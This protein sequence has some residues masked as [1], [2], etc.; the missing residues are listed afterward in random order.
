[1]NKFYSVLVGG[2]LSALGLGTLPAVGQ[3][4]PTPIR[5]CSTEEINAQIQA[6]LKRTIPGYDPTRQTAPNKKLAAAR[7]GAVTYTLPVIV[8]VIHNGEAVGTGSN[9]SQAQVQSQLDVLNEDYRNLNVDGAQVPSVYQ[10]RRGDMQVQFVNA[11]RDPNG[12]TLAEPGIDRINRN[13][14]GWTAPPYASTNY[15]NGTIKPNSYWDPSRYINIWVLNLGGGLLGYAQ[16][17]DNTAGLGGLS[18]LGGSA[19]TDGVVVLYTSYGSRVKVPNG[20]FGGANNVYDR[21]RTLTHELGHWFGFRH[22]WGDDDCGSDYCPDTPVQFE[23]NYGCVTFPHVTCSNVTGDMSMNYMDYTDD[24]CMY[25]FT[26]GQKDR[27]QAVMQNTPRRAELANSTV[28]CTSVA[29]ATA[30]NS[31]PACVGGSITL[32]ATG[33]AGATYTWDGP[34]GF[35]STAQNP[36]IS[37]VT[38]LA[39]GLY[40][41]SVANGGC[42]GVASTTVVVNNIPAVPVLTPVTACPQTAITLTPT[43]LTPTTSTLPNENFNGTATGWTIANTG[44]AVTTWQYSSGY[45]YANFGVSNF[46]LNGSRFAIANSDAGGSGS[47]TNT[48]LTSPVFSTV[49]YSALQLSFQQIYY[50]YEGVATVEATTDGGTTW[51]AVATYRGQQGALGTASLGA[52]ITSTVNLSYVL[53]KPSVQLRWHYVDAYGALWAIDNVQFTATVPTLTYNWT[54]VSGD[55]L[56]TTTNAASLTATPTQSSVYR[57][58]VGFAGSSCTSSST[59]SVNVYPTPVL[60]SSASVACTGSPA[61]LSATNLAGFSPTYAWTLVS[62][63]GLPAATNAAT[64]AVTPTQNSVYRLTVTYPGNC[65]L[66]STVSV[67]VVPTPTLVASASAICSGSTS[68]LS[69]TNVPATGYTYKWE[70]VS[71]NGLSATATTP[72]ITVNPTQ[73]SLYRLT[74]T[75]GTC[76]N[77]STIAVAAINNEITAYPVPFGNDGHSLR[78][79][80][81]TA[82]P[83]SVH[84]YDVVGHRIYDNV[85]STPAV[86]VTTINIPETARLRPGKYIVKVQQGAQQTSFNV[87]RQ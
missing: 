75:S 66:S 87:V 70:L 57:L 37:N 67:A 63:D 54:L 59:V 45:T 36:T 68:Q 26:Q 71:G 34:N 24:R 7:T 33:P 28:G 39:A 76:S 78:V 40:K 46:T 74:I 53:N 11:L 72:T 6:E 25:M 83:A 3:T 32:S 52:P 50:P 22:I 8:H 9:I 61:T 51:I 18:T 42:P 15:I 5:R 80:T 77:S 60:V 44:A 10:S 55:G 69:A 14:K 13:A 58:T 79:S 38:A 82:G 12:N 85:V 49:G 56:P 84:I 86:G 4:Q 21:G 43:G 31:G 20:N 81:C 29:P 17:P 65:S 35:T 47:T 1:M 73:N 23:E 30:T 2:L 27:L 16:F 48:T 19:A 64:L 62:G 41:V